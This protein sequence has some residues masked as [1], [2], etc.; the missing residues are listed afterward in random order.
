MGIHRL[1]H[2]V[3]FVREV[4]VSVA[5]YCNVLGF[6]VAE[7]MAGQAA[8]LRAP[9]STNDHDLGLFQ[10]GAQAT[11]SA[12]GKGSVGLYH[13]A[14]EVSTLGDLENLQGVL[15]EAGASSRSFG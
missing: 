5:F 14:W 10:M 15:A 8:F 4:E 13:L 12:A 1:N 9:E 3:L 6:T 2:A 7:T 11:P